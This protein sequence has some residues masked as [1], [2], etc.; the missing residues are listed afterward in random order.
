[1]CD[2]IQSHG[3]AGSR[4]SAAPVADRNAAGTE[5]RLSGRIRRSLVAAIVVV[6][7]GCGGTTGSTHTTVSSVAGSSIA[8]S[9]TASGWSRAAPLPTAR[10]ALDVVAT[11]DGRLYA[12]GGGLAYEHPTGVAEVY[13][14]ATGL[15]AKLPT[16]PQPRSRFALAASRSGDIYAF[17]GFADNGRPVDEIDKFTPG[18]GTWTSPALAPHS[19]FPM[20]GATGPDG[21]VYMLAA[22]P[23]AIP[24]GQ[25]PDVLVTYAPST[26]RW[27]NLGPAP[28]GSRVGVSMAFSGDILYIIGGLD[29]ESSTQRLT[30]DVNTYS[31]TTRRWRTAAPAPTPLVLAGVAVDHRGRIFLI[32]GATATGSTAQVS[33]FDPATGSWTPGPALLQSVGG[34]GAATGIDGRI[35]AVGGATTAGQKAIVDTV[36]VLTPAG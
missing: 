16:M 14:P 10:T 17:G 19:F 8:P 9:V 33:I 18:T 26:G 24:T 32:G 31:R 2:W 13:D 7:A 25:P 12:I 6:V 4:D 21:L 29:V 22:V 34:L 35:Y 27:R 1:M 3:W 5:V 11:P 30:A 20:A 23:N 36:E 28:T 15:W